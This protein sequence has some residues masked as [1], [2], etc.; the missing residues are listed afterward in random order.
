MRTKSAPLA[1]VF[2]AAGLALAL[3]GCAGSPTSEVAAPV[4]DELDASWLLTAG[5]DTS[6]SFALDDVSITLE[7]DGTVASGNSGCN[8]YTGDVETTSDSVSFGPFASTRMA[9]SPET[10]MALEARYLKAL[11]AADTASVDGD[12]LTL[13]LNDDALQLV[14]T[15]AGNSS[16]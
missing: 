6:G 14:F 13:S 5:T 7:I 4:A 1:A 10:V 9:C 11:E 3:A 2:A 12:T 15:A 16:E 8:S